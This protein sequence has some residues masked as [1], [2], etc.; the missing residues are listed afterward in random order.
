MTHFPQVCPARLSVLLLATVPLAAAEAE[1]PRDVV[2]DV[3][4]NGSPFGEHA[5]RFAELPGGELQVDIDIE[6]RV[7]FGPVTVFRYEHESEEVWADGQLQRLEASTLKDGD[8]ERYS[9]QRRSDGRFDNAGQVIEALVPSSHWSGYSPG[10]PAVLNTETGEPME[11]EIV[12]L[13]RTMVETAGGPVAARHLRM[14]GTVS[15][16]LWYDDAGR[17]VGCAFTIQNQD[18]V[19][20][21]RDA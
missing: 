15:V 11:V 12:D 13:G 7:G 18:I 8:R 17:W 4:R 2:F 6:L 19:Y 10:L 1:T 14:T 3:F 20:R 9:L 21:L 5:V 16:D